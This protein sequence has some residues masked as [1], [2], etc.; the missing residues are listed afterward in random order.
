MIQGSKEAVKAVRAIVDAQSGKPDTHAPIP[1][2]VCG[3]TAIAVH[4]DELDLVRC[5]GCG[6]ITGPRGSTLRVYRD[7]TDPN[8]GVTTCEAPVEIEKAIA[9]AKAKPD[10]DKTTDEKKLAKVEVVQPPKEP[11]P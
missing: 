8:T 9:A 2:K 3:A 6:A 1:C 4:D 10:K 5:T 7:T 11:K